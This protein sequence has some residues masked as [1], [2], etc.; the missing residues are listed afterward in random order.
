[1]RYEVP[2][3]WHVPGGNGYSMVDIKVPNP[4]AGGLP[5]A[6]V[7]SGTGP[8]RTGQKRFYPTDYSNIGPRLGAA[9]QL[10]PKTVLRGGWSIYYQGLSSGGC[11]CRAGFA[12]SNDLVSDGRNAVLNWDNGIPLAPGYRPPPIIDPSYVNFQSVQ[13]QGSTAGQAGRIYNWSFNVQHEVKNF[14]IDV[15]YQGNRGTRLNSTVDLNQL[16]ASVLSR[17][18]L[19]SARIDSPAAAAAGVRAPFANFPGGQSVAQS[20]RPFPQYLSVSS[21]FAG[22]G[23]SWYDAL[24]TKVERRF[25]TYQLMVN[26][27][28][29]KSLGNG[30]F[31]QVFN[32]QG[33]QGSPQDYNNLPDGKSFMPFDIPHVLNILS[34]FD[35][36]FGKGRK[37]L[38]STNKITNALVSGWTVSSAQVYRKG[39]LLQL[40]TPGNPLGNGV[41][42]APLTKA[43]MSAVPIRTGVER[44]SLDPNNPTSRFFNAAAFSAAPQYTL[45]TAAFYQNDFRQPSVFTENLSIVKRT[46]LFNTDKNPVVLTYRTD[47]FNIFNRTSFGGVN[48]TVGNA[49]FGRPTGPQNGARLI[50]MGLRLEF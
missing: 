49:N 12:G 35:M 25:G 37:Y 8:G 39:T 6:L 47:G 28:W 21:L 34:T 7:F 16:P 50:T 4:A 32:Q 20:L 31:R 5:G 1:M 11:G 41:L 3:G 15:A 27:T 48:G 19:L 43:N 30:H 23:K 46:T 13:Y 14:L 45:G 2:I 44:T 9:Y 33:G 26:Y 22:Y 40:V 42:F 24:Q 29:S 18:S 36:P 17:G 10:G 38:S